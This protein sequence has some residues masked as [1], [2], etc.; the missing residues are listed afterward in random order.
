MNNKTKMKKK[1]KEF[2]VEKAIPFMT[3]VMWLSIGMQKDLTFQYIKK[4]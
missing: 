3:L 1:K 2:S 4:K